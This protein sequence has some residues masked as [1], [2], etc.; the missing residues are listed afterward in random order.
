MIV[1]GIKT[2]EQEEYLQDAVMSAIN[3]ADEI[4]IAFGSERKS[5]THDP[6]KTTKLIGELITANPGKIAVIRGRWK[7]GVEA[8]NAMWQMAPEGEYFIRLEGNE[9]IPAAF[10]EELDERLF[11]IVE[12]NLPLYA[13]TL[14]FYKDTEHCIHN[15]ILD[16]PH[17]RGRMV[18]HRIKFMMSEDYLGP[19]KKT[20]QMKAP[21][22]SHA[23]INIE[24]PFEN[25]Q[26]K[27]YRK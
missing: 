20:I 26:I 10:V 4:I 8:L 17:F 11:D 14:Y 24:H 16:K 21:I 7:S 25:S 27:P 23:Y 2:W 15:K 9:I 19:S 6:T 18:N 13:Q 3:I 22:W 1:V 5:T 12:S